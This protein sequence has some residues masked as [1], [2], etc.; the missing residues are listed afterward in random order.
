VTAQQQINVA[1]IDQPPEEVDRIYAQS[2][3]ELA[4][5][6]GGRAKL[7]EIGDE[8]EQLAEQTGRDP[9][10][11]EFFNSKIIT[12]ADKE[13]VLRAGFTGRMSEVVCSFALLLAR[14]ERLDRFR[15]IVAAYDQMMQDRFGIIEVDIYTRYPLDKAE[16][17]A[18]RARLHS[19]LKREPV[20]HAYVDETMIGGIK[21]QVG[22]KLLDATVD[23]QLRHMRARLLE[24]GG[25]ALRA[26]ID[27]I[28]ND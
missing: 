25:G 1:F 7:E 5:Q 15:R 20:V 4:E 24:Q 28:I 19:V 8:L 3:F 21:F 2:L 13:R 23:A 27:R 17:E 26:R 18:I 6:Q 11:R 16:V 14:R 12:A 22:D 9:Q 10:M